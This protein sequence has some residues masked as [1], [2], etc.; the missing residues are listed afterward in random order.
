MIYLYTMIEIFDYN[1]RYFASSIEYDN[2]ND[3]NLFISY[4]KQAIK[5]YEE[6]KDISNA[7]RSFNE[8]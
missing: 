8:L 3:L 7:K 1:K 6:C 4:I 2:D 5:N